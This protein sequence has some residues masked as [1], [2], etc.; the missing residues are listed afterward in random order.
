MSLLCV[1]HCGYKIRYKFDRTLE[2]GLQSQR[3]YHVASKNNFVTRNNRPLLNIHW[4]L[5]YSANMTLDH[6]LPD[7]ESGWKHL[8]YIFYVNLRWT[9]LLSSIFFRSDQCSNLN[10]LFSTRVNTYWPYVVCIVLKLHTLYH[11]SHAYF[12]IESVT[13]RTYTNVIIW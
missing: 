1:W 6:G 13:R 11:M 2:L 5:I 7:V 4:M 9:S 8:R 10:T 3:L 12:K